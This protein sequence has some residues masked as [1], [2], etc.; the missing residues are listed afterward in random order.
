MNKLV[1]D[2]RTSGAYT[3]I[4]R[5]V[6]DWC[7]IGVRLVYDWCTIGVYDWCTI[8][9]RLLYDWCTIADRMLSDWFT[10]DWR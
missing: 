10:T 4:L 7:T 5:L 8:G 1:D 3:I 9:V 2:W 6:H